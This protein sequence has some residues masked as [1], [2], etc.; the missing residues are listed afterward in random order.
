MYA[1]GPFSRKRSHIAVH[2]SASNLGGLG[3]GC[4]LCVWRVGEGGQDINYTGET[5]RLSSGRLFVTKS[6]PSN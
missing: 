2:E 1:L 3:G 5:I 4:V 6:R